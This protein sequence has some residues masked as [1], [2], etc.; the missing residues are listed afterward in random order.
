MKISVHRLGRPFTATVLAL[1]LMIQSGCGFKD[2]DK[3]IFVLSVGID[4]TDNEEKPYKIILKLAVPSG[5][6]KQSGTEYTY[7]TKES[8]SIASAIRLLKTQVDKEIDFGHAKVIVLGKEILHHDLTEVLDIFVRRR[9]IQ[10]ISWV[11]VGKPN[12]ESVLKAEPSSEM[13]GS[14]ALFNLFDQNGVESSYIV[15]TF[16]FD[17]RRRMLETG[18][19]PILP[20]LSASK[21][22]KKIIVNSSILLAKNKDPLKLN[23]KETKIYNLLANNVQRTDLTVKR[24][25]LQYTVSIDT[26]KTSFKIITNPKQKPVIKMDIS[27]EGIIE[28]SNQGMNINA[29]KTFSKQASEEA[30]KDIT[31]L[32]SKLQENEVDPLG[33]GVRYKA[34]RLH[35][36]DTDKEW[37]RLYPNMSFDVNVKVSIMSTGIIE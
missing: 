15:T 9:D 10:R 34:T 5:S 22:K 16:L 20:V 1:S 28:E 37:L 18:I 35:S 13:A 24:D 17:L 31:A 33:F 3:R 21:D 6:L 8:E 7:L 29:L 30:N 14:H 27:M 2:I 36:K 32:L 11:A 25:D 23:P 19:D 4:H 26:A 12:A